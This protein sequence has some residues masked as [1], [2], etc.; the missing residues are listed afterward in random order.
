MSWVE[1]VRT[2]TYKEASVM[3]GPTPVVEQAL[4]RPPFY[5]NFLTIL[6]ILREI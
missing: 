5:N 6:A 4:V 1:D 2:K 3:I